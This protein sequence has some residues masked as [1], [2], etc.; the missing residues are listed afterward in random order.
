MGNTPVVV[1]STPFNVFCITSG[2]AETQIQ[3]QGTEHSQI[4]GENEQP[5]ALGRHDDI[6]TEGH[7][8][9]SQEDTGLHTNLHRKQIRELFLRVTI[10]VFLPFFF[11][12]L[13]QM[14]NFCTIMAILNGLAHHSINRLAKTFGKVDR[15]LH[16]KL[17]DMQEMA[18][19]GDNY[20][21]L[22]DELKK[23]SNPCIP[24]L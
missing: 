19:P 24:Y 21:L 15:V 6:I 3:G 22:R 2:L 7:P 4:S 18:R 5:D 13:H 1:C 12:H 9:E 23:A 16:K 20:R 10:I 8:A 14:S 11:Q 17:N